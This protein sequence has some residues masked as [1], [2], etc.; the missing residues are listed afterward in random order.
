[1]KFMTMI[2]A[3]MLCEPAGQILTL[4]NTK[5]EECGGFMRVQ[6]MVDIS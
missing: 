4:P 1:M 5:T 3:E 2:V 6:V